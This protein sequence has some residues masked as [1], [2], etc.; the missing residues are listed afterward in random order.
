[1]VTNIGKAKDDMTKEEFLYWVSCVQKKSFAE[2]MTEISD[3]YS[4]AHDLEQSIKEADWIIDNLNNE[5]LELPI[6]FDWE[7][8][9]DFN[10]FHISYVKLNLIAENFMNRLIQKG[11]SSGLYGSASYLE[12]IWDLNEYNIWL[13]HYTEKTDYQNKYNIWQQTASGIV[14]GIEG[15]VDLH[16]IKK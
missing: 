3:F 16:I 8:W 7:C 11:Y 4:K 15:N 9:D 12:K 6:Y 1:M 2:V 14:P 13:A 10:S 5:K